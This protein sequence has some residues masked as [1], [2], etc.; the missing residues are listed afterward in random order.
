M[1]AITVFFFAVLLNH[2]LWNS[3]QAQRSN[4]QFFLDNSPFKATKYLTK[5]NRKAKELPP[6]AYNEM[7]W[8]R[9]MN[10]HTGRPEPEK[11]LRIQNELRRVQHNRLNTQAKSQN[12][13]VWTE[14]GPANLGGR[15]RALLFDP[16]DVG[17]TNPQDDYNR[18]FA[19]AVSGGLWV[20]E[21][22]TDEYS[23]WN[24]VPG[25]SAN[26]S[27]TKIIAD[28]NNSN[29]MY[30]ASGESYTSGQAI[31]NGIWKSIDGG[32]T[33]THVFGG[34]NGVE[35]ENKFI[36]GIFYV[37]DIVA[38]DVG[39]NTELFITVAGSYFGE[40][41]VLS[42]YHSVKQQGLY[43]SVDN[44]QNWKKIDINESNGRPINPN[45]LEIDLN[46]NIWITTNQN[47][48]GQSGGKIY[49]SSDGNQFEL[50]YGGEDGMGRTELEPS[51]KDPNTFWILINHSNQADL[52]VTSDG[53]QTV[54]K[55]ETEPNDA[56][57]DIDE[58][59]FTR[60]QAFYDLEIE[61]DS[62]D[63]L[64]V[65]G[66]DLFRSN[67]N[68]QTWTQ[69]SHWYGGGGFQNV[70]A[71]QHAIVF[72]PGNENQAIFGNDGGIYFCNDLSKPSQEINISVRNKGYNTSQFYYG[73]ID[74]NPNGTDALSGGTQDNGTWTEFNAM[75]GINQ[76]INTLGGDGAYTELDVK[77]NYMISSYVFDEHI[78]FSYPNISN[79]YPISSGSDKGSFINT[80]VLDKKFDIL[81]HDSSQGSNYSLT[82]SSNFKNGASNI[83]RKTLT[84]PNFDQ[85][86][87][88]LEVS[89]YSLQGTTLYMGLV[90]GKLFRLDHAS[91]S[92]KWS[93]I[94][95]KNF[96]GSISDIS[97][98]ANERELFVTFHNYGVT[99]IWHSKNA[100]ETWTAI[101][102]NLPDMPVRC[103]LQNPN[104]R[105]ELIIG[106]PLGIWQTKDFEQQSVKWTQQNNGI[107]SVSI[108]DLDLRVSDN[109]VLASTHGRGLFTAEFPKPKLHI[110]DSNFVSKINIYPKI[111]KGHIYIVSNQDFG[112]TTFKV[113][114]ITGQLLFQYNLNLKKEVKNEI[115]IQLSSGLYLVSIHTAS[116]NFTEKIIIK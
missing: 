80:V 85:T 93:E 114:S 44:G 66:I 64:Y 53:F 32:E 59:D 92:P 97:F 4:H 113:W 71:D 8:E 74:T 23:N 14:R 100:G 38:R 68:A 34:Y 89:P 77:D 73:T 116:Q 24:L 60:G 111:S 6:N 3:I 78:F 56:D 110:S 106:T 52:Y 79:N 107:N 102:G 109:I 84:N 94:T 31:G 75:Q 7:L 91:D 46:N 99:N 5:K 51:A 15:T 62:A 49:K 54:N 70:H 55:I 19:G 11:L 12:E 61:V 28:P 39:E 16:N 57:P 42:Q 58:G 115:N 96:L 29:T 81:Y 76:F 98:G 72:R 2:F 86:P 95:G 41:G 9:S 87:S 27:I 40:S 65:G 108:V 48:W 10:P 63:N 82:R 37:N 36:N 13:M 25:L 103:I 22:I 101:D 50:M 67:N 21:N 47:L 35:N 112:K 26:I 45:D 1:T 105:K 18:V 43:K 33:W 104:N 88:A 69:L 17:N 90:N 20:N 83:V 30:I